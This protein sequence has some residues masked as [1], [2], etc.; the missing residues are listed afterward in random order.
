MPCF[1]LN[2]LQKMNWRIQVVFSRNKDATR[3]KQYKKLI[4]KHKNRLAQD[5]F[6]QYINMHS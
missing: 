3:D 5:S 2:G 1:K 6:L 4:K